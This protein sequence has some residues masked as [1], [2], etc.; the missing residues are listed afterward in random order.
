[1]SN[2]KILSHCFYCHMYRVLADPSSSVSLIHNCC[3][4]YTNKL[5]LIHQSFWTLA[6]IIGLLWQQYKGDKGFIDENAI[7]P[8]IILDAWMLQNDEV[9]RDLNLSLFK[10]FG[11]NTVSYTWGENLSTLRAWNEITTPPPLSTFQYP[12]S[13]GWGFELIHV[14][15]RK[16][17]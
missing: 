3:T 6:L 9:R 11:T 15:I 13:D 12:F 10:F 4:L 2:Q 8:K 5:S 7:M 16:E 1:M 17:L 14:T